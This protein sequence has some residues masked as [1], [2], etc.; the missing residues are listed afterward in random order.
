MYAVVFL[1]RSVAFYYLQGYIQQLH[2]KGDFCLVAFGQYPLLAIHL[3]YVVIRAF[4]KSFYKRTDMAMPELTPDF[5]KEFAAY[6]LNCATVP[7]IVTRPM[8]G[9]IPFLSL[10][11][12]T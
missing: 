4:I 2:L 7:L 12:F 6:Q 8:M 3:H 1:H 11:P 10:L 5:I 9:T